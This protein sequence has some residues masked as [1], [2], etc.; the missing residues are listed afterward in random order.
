MV[1]GVIRERIRQQRNVVVRKRV[2]RKHVEFCANCGRAVD[3]T[4]RKISSTCNRCQST[5]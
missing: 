5:S 1:N 4:G 3:R 2:D